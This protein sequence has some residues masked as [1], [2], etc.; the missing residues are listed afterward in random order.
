MD[1]HTRKRIVETV[2]YLWTVENLPILQIPAPTETNSARSNSTQWTRD[3]RE[4][5]RGIVT[6]KLDV[7]MRGSAMGQLVLFNWL[8]LWS[9][10]PDGSFC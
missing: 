4:T 8:R 10:I 2:T 1:E 7:L 3:P 9:S 5:I 6:R